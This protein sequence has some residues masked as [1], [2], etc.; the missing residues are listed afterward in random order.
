MKTIELLDSFNVQGNS[1]LELY[2]KLQDIDDSTR[3]V[4]VSTDEIIVWS[5]DHEG[6]HPETGEYGVLCR[7]HNLEQA[8]SRKPPKWIFLSKAKIISG[9]GEEGYKELLNTKFLLWNQ[10]CR[11]YSAFAAIGDLAARADLN[12]AA[13]YCPEA[14]LFSLIM[15]RYAMA[16][17]KAMM[18]VR[19]NDENKV[20]KVIALRSEKYAY[21]PQMT[22]KDIIEGFSEDLGTPTCKEW[23]ITQSLTTV[24]LEFPKLAEDMATVYGLK[25]AIIPGVTLYTSDTGE[26][27]LSA[28]GTFKIRGVTVYAEQ[29][30]RKH[31]GAINAEKIL[32]EI[33]TS[34]FAKYTR[35]PEMLVELLGIDVCYP[36]IVIEDVLRQIDFA[37]IA[38]KRAASKLEEALIDELNPGVR[39]TAYDL[40]MM[41][42]T[43]PER[44]IEAAPTIKE[45][46]RSV[47]YRAARADY[48]KADAKGVVT[49][50]S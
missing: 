32:G 46:L 34:V 1:L 16:P 30:K 27:S 45:R 48:R 4:P 44:Y 2:D 28:T 7:V 13:V 33:E 8:L 6:E 31:S 38:G 47:V 18:I 26:S 40:C 29:Y 21:I 24:R 42:I 14:E 12:G 15:R 11:F 5:I 9:I 43:L 41:I 22:M 17:Q 19:R 10:E 25:D 20:R 3:E 49:L 50:A 37:S 39:Y 35:F 23:S 36:A